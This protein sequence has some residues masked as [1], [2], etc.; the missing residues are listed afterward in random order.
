MTEHRLKM[1]RFPQRP[2]FD[3]SRYE[4]QANRL[5]RRTERVG[6]DALSNLAIMHL[7]TDNQ[8]MLAEELLRRMLVPV[9]LDENIRDVAILIHGLPQV[10]A[11]RR[12]QR[13]RREVDHGAHWGGDDAACGGTHVWGGR[14]P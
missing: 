4:I 11:L 13:P 10:M 8:A 7:R 14:L 9:A 2:R 6:R 12:M 3:V 5:A 1:H